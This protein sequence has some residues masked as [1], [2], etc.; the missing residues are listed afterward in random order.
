MAATINTVLLILLTSSVKSFEI[1]GVYQ[2]VLTVEPG[3][4]VSVRCTSSEDWEYCVWSQTARTSKLC[5]L[6]W[7]RALVSLSVRTPG[8][9]IPFS[10]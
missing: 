2:S 10:Y 4:G 7:K 9:S 8:D 6:E 1:T 5:T 3:Q